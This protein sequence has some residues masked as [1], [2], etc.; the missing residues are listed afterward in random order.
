MREQLLGPAVIVRL[1]DNTLDVHFSGN[2]NFFHQADVHLTLTSH[3]LF[4]CLH[5]GWRYSSINNHIQQAVK[6]RN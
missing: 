3:H 2:G 6:G 5:V 4:C 1:R